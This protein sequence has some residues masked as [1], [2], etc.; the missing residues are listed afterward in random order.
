MSTVLFKVSE[1]WFQKEKKP[2]VLKPSEKQNPSEF[3]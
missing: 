3:Q 2:Q 1:V